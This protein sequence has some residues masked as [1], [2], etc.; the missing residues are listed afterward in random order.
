MCAQK[1]RD[2]PMKTPQKKSALLNCSFGVLPIRS[3]VVVP[4]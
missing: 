3:V 4:N 2:F 1:M